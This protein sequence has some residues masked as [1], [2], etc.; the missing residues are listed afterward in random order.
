[1]YVIPM[2]N[3][4]HSIALTVQFSMNTLELVITLEQLFAI[5]NMDTLSQTHHQKSLDIMN[6]MQPITNQLLII[7][8]HHIIHPQ[9]LII[10]QHQLTIQ[11]PLNH[12]MLQLLIHLLLTHPLMTPHLFTFKPYLSKI[13]VIAI[14]LIFIY[15]ILRQKKYHIPH[16]KIYLS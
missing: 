9:L 15:H 14:Y 4:I 13:Y 1:M 5:V 8:Q 6:H 7:L 10:P 16:L 3:K 12:I 11:Q 2:E